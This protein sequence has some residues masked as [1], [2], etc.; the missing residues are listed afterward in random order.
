MSLNTHLTVLVLQ[1]QRLLKKG[2][3]LVKDEG[4]APKE[5]LLADDYNESHGPI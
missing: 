3:G 5:T 2:K 4:R 1:L